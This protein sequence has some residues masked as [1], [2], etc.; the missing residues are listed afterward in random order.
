MAVLLLQEQILVSGATDGTLQVRTNVMDPIKP[1]NKT[2]DVQTYDFYSGG[3]TCLTVAN[4]LVF[5]G[6]ENGVIFACDCSEV[7]LKRT[8]SRSK[9]LITTHSKFNSCH[10]VPLY[11]PLIVCISYS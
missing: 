9:H 1:P 7:G 11:K 5:T 10:I 4:G 3:I 8:P 2:M 6:G